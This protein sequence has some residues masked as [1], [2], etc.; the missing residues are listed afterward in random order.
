LLFPG[1][2]SAGPKFES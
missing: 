2:T 1:T